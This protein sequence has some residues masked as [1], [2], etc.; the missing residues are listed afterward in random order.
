MKHNAANTPVYLTIFS[1][2]RDQIVNGTL[3]PGHIIPSENELCSRYGTTRETVRKGLKQLEQDGLISSQPRRGYFVNYPRH[4]EFSL[5]LTEAVRQS[6]GRYKDIRIMSPGRELQEAL[7]IPA[8][9]K[10]IALFRGDYLENKIFGLEVKYLP[11]GKG[12]PSIEKELDFAVFPEAARAK[13]T[14]FSYYTDMTVKAVTAPE[15]IRT[16]LECDENEP[17]LMIVKT[18]IT[19]DGKRLAYSKQYLRAPYG[20]LYGSSG[21][22]QEK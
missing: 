17:L 2:L 8:A 6:T 14:S 22:I 18:F 20:E 3:A 15:E 7:Q 10:V 13:S 21:Y 4:D 12:M 9:Q 16:M 5:S 1:D 19:Q 11:Y